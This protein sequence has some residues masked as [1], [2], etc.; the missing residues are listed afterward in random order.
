MNL[1]GEGQTH[2]NPPHHTMFDDVTTNNNNNNVPTGQEYFIT[3]FSRG[4][5]PMTTV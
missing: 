5:V 3:A 2:P 1:W 4:D